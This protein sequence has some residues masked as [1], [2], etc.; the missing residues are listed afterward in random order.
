[1]T[2]REGN[3]F[4]HNQ[5][6]GLVQGEYGKEIRIACQIPIFAWNG[7]LGQAGQYYKKSLISFFKRK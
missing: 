4:F 5:S 3:M 6:G 1:M 2:Q 7:P